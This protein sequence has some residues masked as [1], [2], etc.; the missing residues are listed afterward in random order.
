MAGVPTAIAFEAMQMDGEG[1][2]AVKKT[3]QGGMLAS[4]V[5][6]RV[7]EITKLFQ[8]HMS[9]LFCSECAP[10]APIHKTVNLTPL[11]LGGKLLVFPVCRALR[12]T[13][14]IP[15]RLRST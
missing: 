12:F 10:I 7:E 15:R 14:A 3:T 5:N 1:P 13:E 11:A 6:H 8:L 9:S 4:G 2:T